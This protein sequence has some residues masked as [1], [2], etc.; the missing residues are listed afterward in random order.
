LNKQE[1]PEREKEEEATQWRW[2]SI[3]KRCQSTGRERHAAEEGEDLIVMLIYLSINYLRHQID[4]NNNIDFVCCADG[5]DE[6]LLLTDLLIAETNFLSP[7]ATSLDAGRNHWQIFQICEFHRDLLVCEFILSYRD[8]GF[9][10]A[11]STIS[12]QKRERERELTLLSHPVGTA[13]KKYRSLNIFPRTKE[14][15]FLT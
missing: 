13:P 5:T 15:V 8:T 6:L 11:A 7:H 3:N 12:L 1:K 4:N 14:C 10:C 2:L 9:K